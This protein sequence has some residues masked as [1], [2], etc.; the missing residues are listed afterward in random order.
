MVRA[1]VSRDFLRL[2]LITPECWAV[3]LL[4]A[5]AAKIST[6][7]GCYDGETP[8]R[9]GLEMVQP[10]FSLNVQAGLRRR[11]FSVK[12]QAIIRAKYL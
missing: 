11:P 10:Q 5:D 7:L 12:H 2:H 1:T 4:F 8:P 9:G 3:L 6:P